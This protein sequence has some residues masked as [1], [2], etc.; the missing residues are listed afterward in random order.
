MGNKRFNLINRDITSPHWALPSAKYDTVTCIDMAHFL[1][2]SQFIAM[3]T[4]I[5][6][7]LKDDDARLFL[8][9][10]MPTVKE[11]FHAYKDG[12]RRGLLH[13]VCLLFTWSQSVNT[14]TLVFNAPEI[15]TQSV[16][17]SHADFHPSYETIIKHPIVNASFSMTK[18]T[19]LYYIDVNEMCRILDQTGYDVVEMYTETPAGRLDASQ[20]TLD[21]L[22]RYKNVG[23]AL[24]VIAKRKTASSS[25]SDLAQTAITITVS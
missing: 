15:I 10:G 17:E 24:N 9:V 12:L 19:S 1:K 4:K 18:I 23:L 16:D 20:I 2:P 22:E 14:K 7:S 25:A 8:L 6:P 13:P 21:V 3:L 11:H 5:L